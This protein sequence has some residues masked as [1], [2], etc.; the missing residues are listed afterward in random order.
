[1]DRERDS[2]LQAVIRLGGIKT[3][4]REDTTGEAKG[5]RQIPGVGALWSDKTGTSID[6]MA[7]Q[8]DQLG[9]LPDQQ[10]SNEASTRP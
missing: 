1:M 10:A 2:L 5:N 8:L 9:Y 4:W 6:D 3:E 7:S